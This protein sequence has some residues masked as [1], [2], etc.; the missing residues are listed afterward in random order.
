MSLKGPLDKVHTL[1]CDMQGSS[2]SCRKPRRLSASSFLTFSVP[3][4]PPWAALPSGCLPSFQL[5]LQSS[6]FLR[7]QLGPPPLEGVFNKALSPSGGLRDRG[8]SRNSETYS[9]KGCISNQQKVFKLDTAPEQTLKWELSH[10]TFVMTSD[11]FEFSPFKSLHLHKY[12]RLK[13][14]KVVPWGPDES[15]HL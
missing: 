10:Q 8:E 6:C 2:W 15:K 12:F 11:C 9:V 7:T 13:S 1:M 14:P 5:Q 3:V 4:C